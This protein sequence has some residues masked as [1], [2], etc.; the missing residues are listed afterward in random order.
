[1]RMSNR[2][3]YGIAIFTLLTTPF[4]WS[5]RDEKP[6]NAKPVVVSKKIPDQGKAKADS[7]EDQAKKGEVPNTPPETAAPEGPTTA[8]RIYDPKNRVNPFTPLFR[9]NQD[10]EVSQAGLSKSRKRMPQTPLERISL[11]QLQLKA[12]IRAPSGNRALVEDNSGKGYIIKNGTYI[13]LNAGIVTQINTE[14]VIV[15]EEIENLMGEL[16]LQNTEIKL[17]KKTGE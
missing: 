14:S 3:L 5:C 11:E 8:E 4:F 2:Y 15:E 12:V 6:E 9:P 16:V 1:M 7:P 10:K 13:G 17:Q